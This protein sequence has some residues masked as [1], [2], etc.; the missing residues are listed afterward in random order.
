MLHWSILLSLWHVNVHVSYIVSCF[1]S[2]IPPIDLNVLLNI[3]PI[4]G[5]E[6][7]HSL[8]HLS[9]TNSCITNLHFTTTS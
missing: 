4:I 5:M 3:L 8:I 7:L 9:L 1:L 2:S 6:F